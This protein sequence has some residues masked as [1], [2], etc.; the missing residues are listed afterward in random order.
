[1][2]KV[3]CPACDEKVKKSFDFCPHCGI[4][5][6][7]KEGREDLG[8]LGNQ[9]SG[10]NIVEELKLPF[11]MNKIVNS[12]VKQ[13]ERQMNEGNMNGAN[14]IP[15]GFK[16]QVSTKNPNQQPQIQAPQVA[17]P[18]QRITAEEAQRRMTLERIEAGSVVKR[19]GDVIVYEIEAPGVAS[20]NDVV[21]TK[22]ASGIEV[23]VYSKDK[24]F[25][26]FIPL[27][28]EVVRYTVKEDK[29]FVE[30]KA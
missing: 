16:I 2:F 18:V 13:L 22:L 8:L 12:L 9:D 23:K 28:V 17:V 14:G 29:V 1:M 6:Q 21:V 25:V 26:K 19:L 11:G 20:K 3:T 15:K 24:C 10:K 7:E 27:S 30:V 5:L 4:M